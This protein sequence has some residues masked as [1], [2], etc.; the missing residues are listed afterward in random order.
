[1]KKRRVLRGAQGIDIGDAVVLALT[2]PNMS[3]VITS[4]PRLKSKQVD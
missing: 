4:A 1:M 3:I 2:L